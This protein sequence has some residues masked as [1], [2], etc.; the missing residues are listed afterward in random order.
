MFEGIYAGRDFA[1]VMLR[2]LHSLL[3]VL[4]TQI[5]EII[6]VRGNDKSEPWESVKDWDGSQ[7][8]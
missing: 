3:V 7:L 8:Q 1:I 2:Q 4:E 5:C 6:Q